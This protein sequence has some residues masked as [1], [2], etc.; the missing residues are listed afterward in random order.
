MMKPVSEISC[1]AWQPNLHTV[2][3]TRKIFVKIRRRPT[4]LCAEAMNTD[5]ALYPLCIASMYERCHVY[6]SPSMRCQQDFQRRSSTKVERICCT[7]M[8]RR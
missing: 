8:Y 5:A 6:R 2:V 1:H 4:F 7:R 3:L